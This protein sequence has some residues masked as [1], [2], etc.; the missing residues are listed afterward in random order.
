[1]ERIEPGK[2]LDLDLVVREIGKSGSEA[3]VFD[4]SGEIVD[5]LSKAIDTSSAHA[6]LIMSNSGFDG[7]YRLLTERLRGLFP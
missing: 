5:Y 6:I 4:T 7:I 2:R 1:M 3:R